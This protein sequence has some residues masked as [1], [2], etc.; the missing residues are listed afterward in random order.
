[1]A[2]PHRSVLGMEHTGD[3]RPDARLYTLRLFVHGERRVIYVYL[4]P[5]ALLPPI[6]G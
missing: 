2:L 4:A 3:R 1:M 6:T 5:M